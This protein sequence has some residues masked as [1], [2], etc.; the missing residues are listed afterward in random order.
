MKIARNDI[1]EVIAGAEKGKQGRVLRVD[2][3]KDRVT[4]EKVRLVKRHRK[5]VRGQATG[6]IVEIEAP[7]HVSNVKLVSR[8]S[9]TSG[10]KN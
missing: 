8:G 7:I 10:G 9:R 1:V 2:H 6:G 3:E 4:V 5:Q